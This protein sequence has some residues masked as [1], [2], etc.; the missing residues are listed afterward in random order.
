[1]SSRTV[2]AIAMALALIPSMAGAQQ[3]TGA[4]YFPDKPFP[5]YMQLWQEGW[6]F[7]DETGAKLI[8]AKPDMALVG[9]S[10]STTRTRPQSP[11]R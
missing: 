8:H 4:Y 2:I 3:L 7:T 5:E 10:S 11:L 9:M 1:M 6:S